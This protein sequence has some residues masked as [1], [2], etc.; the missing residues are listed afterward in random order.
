[1]EKVD[2][3]INLK[4][5]YNKEDSVLQYKHEKYFPLTL[6]QWCQQSL[7]KRGEWIICCKDWYLSEQKQAK[8]E[9]GNKTLHIRKYFTHDKKPNSL[10]KL[11]RAQKS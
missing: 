2:N 7:K 5:L 3:K 9:A 1:M 6:K 10:L 4:E 8:V 11:N